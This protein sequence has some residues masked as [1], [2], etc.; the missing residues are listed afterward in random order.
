MARNQRRRQRRRQTK[1]SRR[2][3]QPTRGGNSA[4]A[5]KVVGRLIASGVRTLLGVLPGSTIT[6]PIADFIFKSLNVSSSNPTGTS[7][8]FVFDTTFPIMLSGQFSI[9]PAVIFYASRGAIQ[10]PSA[11]QE[12]SSVFSMARVLE[13]TVRVI[14][15]NAEGLRN[16]ELILGLQPRFSIDQPSP[17]TKI[18]DLPNSIS[19]LYL[20]VRGT[21]DK[22]L[23]LRYRPRLSDGRTFN[24]MSMKDTFAD[25]A[26]IYSQPVRASYGNFTVSDFSAQVE[27]RGRLE[28]RGGDGTGYPAN[29]P[30]AVVDNLS[31]LGCAVRCLASKR[32]YFF[33]D[34]AKLEEQV[35][36]SG[37]SGVKVSG[38]LNAVKAEP[39]VDCSEHSDLRNTSTSDL[40]DLRDMELE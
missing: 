31:T 5:T 15:T 13:C 16:G 4:N 34:T 40:P 22:P 9:S 6:A 23:T 17:A 12:V 32:T 27:V 21:G 39:R 33:D 10:V 28:L 2:V 24:F 20:S 36:G 1:R 29:Y 11:L 30:A 7:P 37:I 35:S 38:K 8:V 26:V 19:S 3:R 25:V 18:M 14:P